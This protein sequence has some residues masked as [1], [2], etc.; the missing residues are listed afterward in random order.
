MTLQVLDLRGNAVSALGVQALE[1]ARN[2]YKVC[3]FTRSEE[4]SLE[5]SRCPTGKFSSLMR[6]GKGEPLCT[7][8]FKP[9]H[10]NNNACSNE[11]CRRRAKMSCHSLVECVH[12]QSSRPYPSCQHHAVSAIRPRLILHCCINKRRV[13]CAHYRR[14]VA[15]RDSHV[16]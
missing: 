7:I 2:E 14:G 15:S 9:P 1:E 10:V 16:D 3:K 6:I 12:C 4:R 8:L 5:P 11:S 13:S